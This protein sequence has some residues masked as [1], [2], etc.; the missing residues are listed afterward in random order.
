MRAHVGIDPDELGRAPA[1]DD[2]RREVGRI[3]VRE[4]DVDGARSDP[5]FST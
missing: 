1:R 2:D 4:G 5:G 3:D